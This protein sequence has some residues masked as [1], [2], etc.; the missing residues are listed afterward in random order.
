MLTEKELIH[1][2]KKLLRTKKEMIQ[3]LEANQLSSLTDEKF[4]IHHN[5]VAGLEAKEKQI[6][7]AYSVQNILNQVNE[8]LERICRGTYGKCVDTGEDIPY[9]DSKSY[10]MQNVR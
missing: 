5:H 3:M 6:T 4:T 9:G 1:L 7:I 8:A 10:P 2:K